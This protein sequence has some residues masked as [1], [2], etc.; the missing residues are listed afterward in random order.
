MND[1]VRDNLDQLRQ[2]C[3]RHRVRRLDLFG[4]AASGAFDPARSDLDFIV[5]FEPAPPGGRADRY[6]ALLRDLETLLGRRVDL[7]EA[8][9]PNS[10]YF[11]DSVNRTR[12]PV[13]AA[14]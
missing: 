5:E 6:F 10:P 11:L 7:V 3:L 14:A 4:S 2:V 13:Y 8:G 9:A 12:T 1:L